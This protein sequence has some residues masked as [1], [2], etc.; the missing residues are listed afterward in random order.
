MPIY[1]NPFALNFKSIGG[2]GGNL[3]IGLHTAEVQ[4]FDGAADPTQADADAVA[5]LLDD[6]YVGLPAGQQAVLTQLLQQAGHA[7]E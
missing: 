1:M 5:K 7:H 6:L 2:P 3:Q 4:G